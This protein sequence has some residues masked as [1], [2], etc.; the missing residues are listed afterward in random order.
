MALWH[1]MLI[2]FRE[3]ATPEVRQK[4]YDLYQVMGEDCGGKEAG[5]LFWKVD[6][7][8]DLRKGVQLVEIGIFEDAAALERFKNH[9]KHHEMAASL[10]DVAD[11]K[12]GDIMAEYP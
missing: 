7:N 2:A 9:Q 3:D 6:H 1:V 11:W 12:T 5:I 4:V 10:R 8:L